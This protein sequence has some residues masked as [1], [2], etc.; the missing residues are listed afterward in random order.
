M[1]VTSGRGTS[2]QC[3]L[4]L[5]GGPGPVEMTQQYLAGE[6]S[7]LL[8]ELQA[9]VGNS[10]AT[11]IV[12]DLRRTAEIVPPIALPSV[13]EH[14]VQVANEICLDALDRGDTAALVREVTICGELWE[15]GVC[16]GLLEERRRL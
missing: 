2:P 7:F 3:L 15:F 8:G 16:A 6:L 4:D 11:R 14:A 5:A 10:P 1:G 9:A 13:A 12:A